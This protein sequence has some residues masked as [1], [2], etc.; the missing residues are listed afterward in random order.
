MLKPIVEMT[1]EEIAKNEAFM[2]DVEITENA[3]NVS[4][5]SKTSS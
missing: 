2:K 1:E 5:N 3:D 4:Q